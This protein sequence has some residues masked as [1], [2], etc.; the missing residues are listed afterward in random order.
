MHC[1]VNIIDVK[2]KMLELE[3][4]LLVDEMPSKEVLSQLVKEYLLVEDIMEEV[5]AQRD[6]FREELSRID[7]KLCQLDDLN[8]SF[9]K[10][11]LS[12]DS[13]Q[14]QDLK[15]LKSG[16]EDVYYDLLIEED[17]YSLI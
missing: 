14:L 13:S 5:Y 11:L 6:N 1:V 7:Y 9:E 12:C 3:R 8:E 10:L 17:I 2:T 4:M 16:Y 15:E